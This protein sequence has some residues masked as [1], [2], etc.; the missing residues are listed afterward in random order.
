MPAG[1]GGA[2][3]GS[4]PLDAVGP[5]CECGEMP[6]IR[7]S[8]PMVRTAGRA[9]HAKCHCGRLCLTANTHADAKT[10]A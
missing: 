9:G 1:R 6:A 3:F 4:S 10:A 7:H 5:V 2:G 8:R